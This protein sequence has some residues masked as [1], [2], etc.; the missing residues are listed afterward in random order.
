[1]YIYETFHIN[2]HF[3]N[4]FITPVLEPEEK[5]VCCSI[6][7]TLIPRFAY[8]VLLLLPYQCKAKG[9]N[10]RE[11]QC[12]LLPV[13]DVASDFRWEA[14]KE[15]VRLVYINLTV[16]DNGGMHETSLRDEFR[17]FGYFLPRRWIWAHTASEPMFSLPEDYALLSASLLTYQVKNIDVELKEQPNRCL[18]KLNSTCQYLAVGR[19]LL[20]NVT[21]S[22]SS[23]ILHKNTSVVCSA[24][25]S[26]GYRC[27]YVHKEATGAATIRCDKTIDIGMWVKIVCLFSSFFLT[28][29]APALPLALPDFVFNLEDE[30]E[31]ENHPADDTNRET[32]GYQRITN[33]AT[34]GQQ[35][36][37]RGTG[38]D[39]SNMEDA[40]ATNDD[41][42]TIPEETGQNTSNFLENRRDKRKEREF[43][44]VDDS[45]PM[46]L[47]TLLRESVKRFPDVALSFNVKL[48]VMCFCVYPCVLYV[49]IGLHYTVENLSLIHI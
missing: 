36:N 44:P 18:A 16:T 2:Y 47:S 20:Q 23:D 39:R 25:G 48:A 35:G 32:T 43:I 5:E 4:V 6:R 19:M 8:F 14:S 41:N 49:G 24:V 11:T 22:I 9:E 12:R 33:P 42:N 45:S 29:F 1:M 34:V 7:M 10:C 30:V 40:T 21:S 13:G 3:R 15:G 38:A 37:Q 26:V 17:A 31:K 28:L 46:I 27:C